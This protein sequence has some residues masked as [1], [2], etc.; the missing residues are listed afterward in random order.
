[1]STESNSPFIQEA[2]SNDDYEL[3]LAKEMAMA[4]AKNPNLTPAEL[5]E[6]QQQKSDLQQQQQQQQKQN[7]NSGKA[8]FRTANEKAKSFAQTIQRSL[9][10]GSGGGSTSSQK[11]QKSQKNSNDDDDDNV[12]KPASSMP[13]LETKASTDSEE[14]E[15]EDD[16]VVDDLPKSKKNS[17]IR[18][19]GIVW[20]RRSGLGKYSATAAWERRRIVLKGN[21]LAY[22]K[23][24]NNSEDS[25]DTSIESMDP[26]SPTAPEAPVKQNAPRPSTNWLE[27]SLKQATDLAAN[28]AAGNINQN[29]AAGGGGDGARGYLDL[30]KENA[31]VSASLGHSGAPTPFAL[32][33]KILTQTKW[34]FCF[35]SQAE[36]MQWLA[37]LTDVIV[38]ASVDSYN[39]VIVQ[40]SDPKHA[41][42]AHG[43]LSEPPLRASDKKKRIT[44]GGHRLWATGHYK[45]K[46][47]NFPDYLDNIGEGELQDY[48][49]DIM[50]DDENNNLYRPP[51]S[52][53]MSLMLEPESGIPVYCVPE[54]F[55]VP[56][57]ILVNMAILLSRASATSVDAFWYI[58]AFTNM[59][60][61]VFVKRDRINMEV[62]K[63][64]ITSKMA[65][66]LSSVMGMKIL[67]T[68]QEKPETKKSK[69]KKKLLQKESSITINEDFKPVAGTSAMRIKSIEEPAVNDIGHVFAGWMPGKASD[70][71]VRSHGYKSTRAKIPSPG[72]LYECTNMD[73]LDGRKRYPDMAARVTL[74]DVSFPDDPATKTWNA[75]DRF[76][77]SVSL[78]TDPPKLYAAP[79]DGGGYTITMYYTMTQETRDILKR[80]TADGYD[81]KDEPPPGDV[82]K[83]K[84]NAVRL[85]EEWCRLAPTDNSWMSRMKVVPMGHNF[86]EIGLPGWIAKYNGKPFLIKRPGQTGFLYRHPEQS[87]LEFDISLYPFPYIA[88]QGICFIK[89]S[90]L[91]KVV[92]SFGFVIEGR[93][94]DELPECLIGLTTLCYPDPDHM[95]KGDDFFAGTYPRSYELEGSGEAAPAEE[96]ADKK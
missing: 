36:M 11:S 65:R 28:L 26:S 17:K 80:I 23:N 67:P 48:E 53:P 33:V 39:A 41:G 57:S 93:S 46:S 70:V 9:S 25:D 27:N 14:E 68:V 15:E 83:S 92:V 30:V 31:S 10:N 88:K 24:L 75:P 86:D 63:P 55:L 45:V 35:D 89:D 64:V 84:L 51:T 12:I 1:M 61:F 13:P 54:D 21:R 6:L 81:P 40:S 69:K 56:L 87:C 74:P 38:K 22:Y 72:E 47:E 73:I 66:R 34:K 62:K 29:D 4:I 43:Q 59:A 94:D 96:G 18:L 32:S 19:T 78:P 37:V 85:F 8:V 91:K 76:I 7:S 82:Q 60:M 5:K 42:E 79:E 20:K 16:V 52:N 44:V 95:L 49:D 3:K 2:P 58:F 90:Y 77:I 50:G 71:Q